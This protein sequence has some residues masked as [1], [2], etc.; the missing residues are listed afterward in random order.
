MA[1][2]ARELVIAE[3]RRLFFQFGFRRVTMDEIAAGLKM[4]KKTLYT[5]FPAKEDL[6]RAVVASI[7]EPNLAKI[8]A[9]IRNEKTAAGFFS[10]SIA[11]FHGLSQCISEPMMSDMRMMPEIWHEVETRRLKVLMGIREVLERGKKS[12]EIRSD[13]HIDLFLKVFIMMVNAV[14]NPAVMLELNM[15]PTDLADQISGIF[16][17]GI[18][19]DGRRKGGAK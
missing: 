6:V 17:H 14:G 10:G 1:R 18:M 19:T 5:L 4:S 3:A 15:K 11:V 9:L 12:G 16:F 13:L 2:G 8:S 7:I